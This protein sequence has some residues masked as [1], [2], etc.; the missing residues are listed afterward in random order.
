MRDEGWWMRGVLQLWL[1][2][3]GSMFFFIGTGWG[4]GEKY[5]SMRIVCN[6]R[7]KDSVLNRRFSRAIKKRVPSGTLFIMMMQGRGV[8]APTAARR[9]VVTRWRQL[10]TPNRGRRDRSCASKRHQ[11][12]RRP[13]R[14]GALQFLFS[15]SYYFILLFNF[16]SLHNAVFLI[17]VCRQ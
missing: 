1:V 10:R 8:V 13:S 11:S 2:G 4:L 6:D 7:G 5:S 12:W 14:E 15:F 17:S 3:L 9:M 16:I